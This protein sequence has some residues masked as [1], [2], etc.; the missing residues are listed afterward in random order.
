MKKEEVAEMFREIDMYYP[1]RIEINKRRVDAWAKILEHS[2]KEKVL[3]RLQ[4]YVKQNKYPP[5][6]S[7]VYVEPLRYITSDT[8]LYHNDK[9]L[10]K[11]MEALERA[12]RQTTRDRG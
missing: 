3:L 4:Q 12:N 1:N 8:P 2:P 7:D 6:P 11:E 9:E 5:T 10:E